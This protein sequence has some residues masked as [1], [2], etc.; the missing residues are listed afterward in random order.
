MQKSGVE[1]MKKRPVD[2]ILKAVQYAADN[3]PFYQDIWKESGVDVSSICS[4]EEFETLPLTDKND[5]RR[6]YPLGIQAVPSKKV[7]R[8]H[9]S[10]GTTGSP[11]II[12]YTQ[13]DI[14]D[15]ATMFARCY[16]LAGITEEDVIQIT[17]GYGLWTAGIGFQAGAEKLG[18]MVVPMGPGNTEKQL[19]M[20]QDLKSTV[21]CATSSYALLVAEQVEKRGLK[22]RIYLKKGII[23][24]ERW[25]DKMRQTIAETLGIELFDVYGLTEVYGPGIALDC[26]YHQGMHY[27]DD[28]LYFE[29]IDPKT[30]KVLPDGEMGELVITTLCKEAAPLVRYRTHDITRILPQDCP[31]G[32]PYPMIDRIVGRTDDMTKVKGVNIYPGQIDHVLSSVP[33]VASEYQIIINHVN[34]KDTIC[35]R[36]EQEEGAES[37]RVRSQL[38][39]GFKSKIGVSVDVELLP[40][41]ELPRSEKK[42]RRVYDYR[43]Q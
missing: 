42:T 25:G 8:V 20:M 22:D 5:L 21:F 40:L 35:L 3:S 43:D 9:S 29:I 19:M 24:S 31:C 23:G 14:D 34:G 1:R 28:Y 41:G 11:V 33:G 15:W 2:A 27:W 37:D 30:G 13:K 12:P 17:P 6:A 10:S 18:A 38:L 26:P 7:V 36:V 32:S 16:A 39:H 4:M